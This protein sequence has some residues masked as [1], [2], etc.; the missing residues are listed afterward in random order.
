MRQKQLEEKREQIA[1]YQNGCLVALE[2]GLYLKKGIETISNR[3]YS[4]LKAVPS[5]VYCAGFYDGSK[6]KEKTDAAPTPADMGTAH[7]TMPTMSSGF[8]LGHI[9]QLNN[10]S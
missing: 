8:A 7:G 2:L 10:V 6:R 1:P 3:V 5:V 9:S 4:L